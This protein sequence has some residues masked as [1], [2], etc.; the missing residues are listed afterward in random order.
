MKRRLP[1]DVVENWPEI[2]GDIDVKAIPLEYV[3]TLTISFKDGRSWILDIEEDI[4]GHHVTDIER[5][6]KDLIRNYEDS[7]ENMDLRIDIK[8][9]KKDI[10]KKTRSFLKSSDK[11]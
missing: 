9:V 8:K 1:K 7:I 4:Q 6:I 2:L 10:I 3:S 5:Q 11:K